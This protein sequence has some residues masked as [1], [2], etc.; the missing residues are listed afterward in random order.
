MSATEYQK[1]IAQGPLSK[2]KA[3]VAQLQAVGKR[4]SAAVEQFCKDRG[5]PADF[6]WEF[7]LI[8]DP[9]M[10]NAWAMPGGKIAFYTGIM[11]LCQNDTGIAVVM[12]HE[13]AHVIARH[14]NERVSQGMLAQFGMQSVAAAMAK[15]PAATQQLVLT[16]LGMGAQYGVML[17]FSRSHEL[18]ADHIGLIVMAMA[19]YDPHYA[20]DFWVRMSQA[21]GGA[22]PEWAS[23]HPANTTRINQIEDNLPEALKYY[24]P[25]GSAPAPKPAAKTTAAKPAPKK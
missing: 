7:N 4:I 8:D 15:Q 2:D 22:P 19:G 21:G 20:K 24:K 5:L 12:G 3:Q 14:G 11:P 23:T 18:E 17:P 13:I 1:T 10:V 16:G 25:T 9:Q 6:Q